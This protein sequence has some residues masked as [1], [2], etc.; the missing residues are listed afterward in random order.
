[1][2]DKKLKREVAIKF[3]PEEFSSDSDRTNR[4]QREAE[5]LASLKPSE[6]RR[7]LRSRRSQWLSLPCSRACRR[8]DT[9]RAHRPRSH[10]T[11][12]PSRFRQTDLR[13]A[14]S[15]TR[16]RH[17]SQGSQAGERK[18]NPRRQSKGSRFRSS[19]SRGER[20]VECCAV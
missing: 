20:T 10:F 11:R 3:L 15:R 14:G 19:Q 6:H 2:R 13:G 17:H 4:F 18:D 1:A 5:V 12:G 16:T 9:G 8:R 7:D